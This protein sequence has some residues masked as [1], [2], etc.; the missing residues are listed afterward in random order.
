MALRC[1]LLRRS[2]AAEGG[3]AKATVASAAAVAAGPQMAQSQAAPQP[4]QRRPPVEP[5]SAKEIDALRKELAAAQLRIAELQMSQLATHEALLRRLDEADRAAHKAA[6]ELRYTALA[7]Q[8]HHDLLETEL[9]RVLA[10]VPHTTEATAEDM[11]RIRRA[12][13]EAGSRE[14]VRKNIG[15]RVE[16]VS[17]E[18]A[19]VV[20]STSNAANNNGSSSSFS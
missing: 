4:H 5:T 20:K 2:Y 13:I 15:F 18:P 1:R 11:E 16:K 10:V 17:E 8:C 19:A 6:T 9:R 3:V 14:M 12:A 7:L